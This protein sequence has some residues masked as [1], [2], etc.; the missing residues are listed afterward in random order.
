MAKYETEKA[1]LLKGVN[2]FTG[3]YLA[4][5]ALTSVFT[6]QPINDYDIYFKTEAAFRDAVEQAYD[7]GMW[8]VDASKRAVT[9]ADGNSAVYQ[10]M[11]F[12]F[13]PEVS[14]IFAAFDF[15]C[16]MGAYDFDKGEMILHDDFLT[17][18]SQRFLRFNPGT[19]YPLATA[20]RVLKY[21]ERGYSIGK[22]DMTR[23]ALACRRVPIGSWDDL[24]DQIGGAY[25]DKVML[26]ASGEFSMDAAIA[27]LNSD[28]LWTKSTEDQPSTAEGLLIKLDKMRAGDVTPLPA[29]A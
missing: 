8:C 20:V 21:Q 2:R 17:H 12:G 13:F 25:G 10:L 11:H 15:T 4:G 1:L 24:K 7:D 29:A 22:G 26:A 3:A 16:C 6:R 28:E 5:G 27:A 23:I 19:K 18:C 14:D 9:F